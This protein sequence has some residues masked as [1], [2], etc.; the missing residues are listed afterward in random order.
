MERNTKRHS[1]VVDLFNHI[2]SG[3]NIY[4]RLD[5]L[6][7]RILILE[8][9]TPKPPKLSGNQEILLFILMAG[10]LYSYTRFFF[11]S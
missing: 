6:D 4:Y 2:T 3:V 1:D 8:I 7:K 9:Y 10:F 11:I 5:E